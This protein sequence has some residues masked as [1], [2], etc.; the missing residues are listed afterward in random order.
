MPKIAALKK[1][2]ADK[3]VFV[4]IC[5]DDSL[6]TYTNYLK[7]NPK[8]D[9]TIWYNYDKSLAKTAK[10]NYFITG[11]EGYYLIN[12]FGYLAQSPALSPSG[13]IEYKLN[14]IFKVKTKT[15]KTGIR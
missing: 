6:K 9:W 8:F 3:V 14:V 5:L 2:F 15:T 7:A 1:K 12:N 4:S 10:E 13:G 11:T